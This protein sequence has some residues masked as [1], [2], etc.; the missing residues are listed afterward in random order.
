MTTPNAQ[1]R[2]PGGFLSQPTAERSVMSSYLE[3]MGIDA[4]LPATPT[5]VTNPLFPIWTGVT[6]EAG[7][8]AEQV[9][10]PG[11]T[12]L[13][14]AA[15]MTAGFGRLI[16]STPTIDKGTL[17]Q[18]IAGEPTQLSFLAQTGGMSTWRPNQTDLGADILT[19]ATRG[20]MFVVGTQFARKLS[21]M[22]WQGNPSVNNPA[23]PGYL[24]F[25][26][27]D[28]QVATGQVD[29]LSNNAIA[30][31][32]SYVGNANFQNVATW[33]VVKNLSEMERFLRHKANAQFGSADFVF[34]MRPEL[35]ERIAE[36]WPIQYNTQSVEYLL[37]TTGVSI[38]VNGDALVAARDA[39]KASG[40]IVINGRT[41]QVVLDDGIFEHNSTNAA[42]AKGTYASTIYM[43]PLRAAGMQTLKIEYMD[44]RYGF[45]QIP[46][47]PAGSV[48]WTD[49]GRYAWALE[50]DKWCFS[51]HA[52][53]E[54]RVLLHTPQIAGKIQRVAYT[55]ATKDAS[56][57]PESP[58][59][60]D[61]GLSIRPQTQTYAVW[62]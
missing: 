23:K 39:M 10:D 16:R 30:A 34:V 12:A 4:L 21:Q 55:A 59:F 50:E 38:N 14:T 3:P 58:Y 41:Y 5:T 28:K 29:A 40:T 45:G 60:V 20:A 51:L 2:G 6:A 7:T 11:P 27:I 57:Y 15:Y 53:I 42:L 17:S 37:R 9:C 47:F 62:K 32:D 18:T 22:I 54:P 43:L 33:D 13:M 1:Y 52:R 56:P 19:N 8:E 31:L 61:G 25:P 44:F 35:W 46:G 26:G 48:S 36:V 49:D 24:E